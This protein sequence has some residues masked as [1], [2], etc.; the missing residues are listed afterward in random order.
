MVAVGSPGESLVN[1]IEKSRNVV[2]RGEGVLDNRMI[3][4]RRMGDGLVNRLAV[5]LVGAA[6]FLGF[7]RGRSFLFWLAL[8][9]GV[10][11]R[12][13][14]GEERWEREGEFGYEVLGDVGRG[15]AWASRFCAAQLPSVEVE[16]VAEKADHL[17]DVLLEGADDVFLELGLFAAVLADH[18]ADGLGLVEEAADFVDEGARA[19]EVDGTLPAVFSPGEAVV[20]AEASAAVGAPGFDDG[21]LGGEAGGVF[22]EEGEGFVVFWIYIHVYMYSGMAGFLNRRIGHSGRFLGGNRSCEL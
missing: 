22:A 20:R 19:A 11:A 1:R 17:F 18:A 3:G 9:G 7:L 16:A 8:R 14:F 10:G 6:D 21:A 5:G 2:L 4:D 12:F 15:E 13:R